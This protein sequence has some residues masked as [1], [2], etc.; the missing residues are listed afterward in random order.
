M[1][2]IGPGDGMCRRGKGSRIGPGL[3][4]WCCLYSEIPKATLVCLDED[5]WFNF[6]YSEFEVPLGYSRGN[7]NK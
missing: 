1:E 5:S 3:G 2:P 4:D 7:L 6:K